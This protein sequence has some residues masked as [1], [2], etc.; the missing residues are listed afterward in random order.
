MDSITPISVSR[1]RIVKVAFASVIGTVIEFYDFFLAGLAATLVWPSVIFAG[2]SANSALLISLVTFGLA[3]ITRPIGA[4]IFGHYGDRIGRKTT[5]I[6]TLVTMGAGTLG[7]GLT[8]SFTSIGVFAGVLIALFRALQ[9][10]GFG[11]EWGGASVWV[12]EFAS[13]SRWRGFWASWVQQGATIGAIFSSLFFSILSAVLTPAQFLSWG[14]RVPFIVGA[15]IILFAIVL[16]FSLTESPLFKQV[17]SEG[18]VQRRPSLGVIR[19][20]WRRIVALSVV[21][22]YQSALFFMILTFS[23][24][25]L[26]T[27]FGISPTFA[28]ISVALAAFLNI[29]EVIGGGIAIDKIGRKKIVYMSCTLG[30]VLAFPYVLLLNT[31]TPALILLAQIVYSAVAAVGFAAIASLFSEHFSTKQRF[32]GASLSFSFG[33]LLG[34]GVAP[35]VAG[36]LLVVY[37][38]AHNAWPYIAAIPVVYSVAALIALTFAKETSKVDISSVQ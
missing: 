31:A 25:Y 29:F 23:V 4:L 24:G 16:R 35:I 10:L 36:A 22:S 34:G 19:E 38:G 11:G 33:D 26:T 1:G 21:M 14:W 6:W 27:G 28:A 13:K 8:P 5:L 18:Q 7:I 32:S 30:I 9:G 37:G 20:Q 3:F 15:I 2:V 12:T 17:V